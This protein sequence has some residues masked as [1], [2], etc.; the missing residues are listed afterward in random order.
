MA[1]PGALVSYA[2][3]YVPL[4]TA[5]CKVRILVLGEFSHT[6]VM[7]VVFFSRK[8]PFFVISLLHFKIFWLL[9]FFFKLLVNIVIMY[10]SITKIN[11][12]I[13]IHRKRKLCTVSRRI[14]KPFQVKRATQPTPRENAFQSKKYPR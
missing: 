11:S 9:F 6:H 13:Y 10:D 1:L 12:H 7:F 4:L 3:L 5:R 2:P 14:P 8:R